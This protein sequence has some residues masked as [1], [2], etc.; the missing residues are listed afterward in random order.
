M[1]QLNFAESIDIFLWSRYTMFYGEGL[2]SLKE[3]GHLYPSIRD[4][5]FCP[6]KSV[7]DIPLADFDSS[8]A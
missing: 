3:R 5:C 2:R 7:W 1:E 6:F 4:T 8:D